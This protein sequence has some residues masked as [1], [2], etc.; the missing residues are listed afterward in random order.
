MNHLA[1]TLA[2]TACLVPRLAWGQSTARE[3]PVPEHLLDM[4]PG[5]PPVEA[6]SPDEAPPDETITPPSAIAYLA[7]TVGETWR[8]GETVTIRWQADSA[9]STVRFFYYGDRCRL[10]G[11]D[12]GRFEGIINGG[13]V[14]NT[15]EVRWAVPWL[16]GPHLNLRAAAYDAD[17]ELVG[18]TERRVRLLPREFKGLPPTC[19]AVSKR[20]QRLYYIEKGETRRMHIVS[21]GASG[22]TTPAMRPGLS[23]RGRGATGKVFNKAPNPFSRLYRV[24]MP[25]WL[26]ITS[27]GSHGIH[28]TSPRYYSRLGRPASHGCI[29]QHLADARALYQ[30]VSVGTPVYV[31]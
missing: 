27:S 25:Y 1:L 17:G 7:P 6:P 22:Y 30:M 5:E 9:V 13:A 24:H 23:L 20:V 12:R 16:D 28:A 11:K 18:H 26:G 10:G 8:D 19:L 14:P 29:R 21:T 3:T 4:A 15:G 31:F 2:L